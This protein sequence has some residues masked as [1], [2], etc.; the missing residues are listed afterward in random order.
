MVTNDT[1]YHHLGHVLLMETDNR[2]TQTT[3]VISGRNQ[4]EINLPWALDLIANALENANYPLEAYQEAV[5]TL[6]GLMKQGGIPYEPTE[7]D[8]IKPGDKAAY[9]REVKDNDEA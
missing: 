6:E 2:D 5:M 8:T 7:E 4:Y 3:V 9:L 1:Q